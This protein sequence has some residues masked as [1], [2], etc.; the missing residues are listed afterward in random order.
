MRDAGVGQGPHPLVPHCVLG[1]FSSGPAP[2][3]GESCSLP[4]LQKF[5]EIGRDRNAQTLIWPQDLAHTAAAALV[6]ART[7]R[8]AAG[9]SPAVPALTRSQTTSKRFLVL[10]WLRKQFAI[11]VVFPSK[12]EERFRSIKPG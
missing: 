10:P 4:A 3:E 5:G 8:V 2:Q 11:A 7:R 12:I 9:A 1:P 6:S